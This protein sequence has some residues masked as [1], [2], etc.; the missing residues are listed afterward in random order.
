MEGERHEYIYVHIISYVHVNESVKGL[1][2]N[3]K[4]SAGKALHFAL[5]DDSSLLSILL[6]PFER[7]T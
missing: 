3:V 7:T 1:G 4:I 6:I 2:L 5:A